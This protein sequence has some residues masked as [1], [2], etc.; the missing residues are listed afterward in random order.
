MSATNT[1]QH[2]AWRLYQLPLL[3]LRTTA[4]ALLLVII[5]ALLDSRHYRR[6]HNAQAVQNDALLANLLAQAPD[7]ATRSGG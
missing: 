1:H 2:I 7:D 4:I 5:L 6:R 3:A